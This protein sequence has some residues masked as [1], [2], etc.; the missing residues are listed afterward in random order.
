MPTD[1][2]SL[3]TISVLLIWTA[4]AIYAVTF[5]VIGTAYLAGVVYGVNRARELFTRRRIRR[6][7]DGVTGAALIA[8]GVRL[9]TE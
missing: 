5:P 7:M 9:A 2:L 6:I 4:I 1:A 3:D 8:F